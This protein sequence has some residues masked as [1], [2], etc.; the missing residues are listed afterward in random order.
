MQAELLFEVLLISPNLM[1]Q[2]PCQSWHPVQCGQ[3][4][5]V[6]AARLLVQAWRRGKEDGDPEELQ[7]EVADGEV[8]LRWLWLRGSG[9]LPYSQM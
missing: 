6:Q 2:E 5:E 3:V 9:L 7:H 4:Q 8:H 1:L